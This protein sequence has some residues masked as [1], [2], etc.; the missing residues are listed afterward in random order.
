MPTGGWN[1]LGVRP[2]I[3]VHISARRPSQRW[4]ADRFAELII[5]LNQR[6]GAATLFFWSPGAENHPQHP[7]DDAKAAT[8]IARVGKDALL[9]PYP[10]AALAD[11]IGA[12]SVCDAVVCSDGG[13]MHLAAGLGKPLACFFGDSLLERWRPW[14]VRHSILQAGSRNVADIPVDE[15]AGAIATL[16]QDCPASS[17]RL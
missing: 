11:L 9:L 10:T 4:P 17:A 14:G 6:H 7:G 12:L 8:V 16:V 13:A 15:A 1:I 2:L 5:A 3:G